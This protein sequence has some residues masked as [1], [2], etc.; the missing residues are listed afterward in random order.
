MPN[1]T[2]E[3]LIQYLYGES[4]QSD[5]EMIAKA[6]QSD[7]SLQQKLTLLKESQQLLDAVQLQQP[8][9]QSVKSILDYARQ[10]AEVEQ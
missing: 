5:A 3:E 10:T 9:R 6:L 1:F 8:R 7:W 4:S 2:P